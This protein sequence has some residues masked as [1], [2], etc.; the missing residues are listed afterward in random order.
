MP[1]RYAAPK[2]ATSTTKR[3]IVIFAGIALAL[4]VASFVVARGAHGRTGGATAVAHSTPARSPL[5]SPSPSASPSLTSTPPPSPSPSVSQA[6][7]DPWKKA[8]TDRLKALDKGGATL[9]VAVLD[10]SDGR[11]AQYNVRP[12][13]T[14]D[15][16]S[17]VKVDILA[18]LLLQAQDEGRELTSGEKAYAVPMIVDSDNAAA[19]SLW[20]IIGSSDGLNAANK[21]LGLTGTTA[22]TDGLWGLTQTTAADQMTLLTDVFGSASELTADSQSYIRD[23]MGRISDG[24]SWGVSAAGDTTGLKNGWLQRTA[25]GLWDINSIGDVTIGGDPCLL[26]VLSVGSTGMNTGVSLVENAAKATASV[27]EQNH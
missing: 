22:G 13:L 18:T 1:G 14:Y 4:F 16:A 11:T 5:S 19:T 25:T 24:Q 21:R 6:A 15:T 10:L 9:S 27:M 23:L 3:R 20:K 26:A 8:L 12:G 17:I 7:D 2:V